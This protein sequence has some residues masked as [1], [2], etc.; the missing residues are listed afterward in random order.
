MEK[1]LFVKWTVKGDKLTEVLELLQQAAEKSRAEAGNILYD[2]FQLE[3]NPNEILLHERYADEAALEAHKNS[4]HYQTVV[5]G[6]ILPHLESREVT[7]V[8][9]IL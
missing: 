9:K 7:L 6:K 2:V 8:K 5:A 4:E 1:E 3:A